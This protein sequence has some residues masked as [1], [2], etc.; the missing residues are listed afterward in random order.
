MVGFPYDDLDR[1]RA[2]YPAEIFATQLEKVADGFDAALAKL[3]RSIAEMRMSRAEQTAFWSALRVAEAAG[4]HFRSVAI[5]ARFIMARKALDAAKDGAT[6]TPQIEALQ[7]ILHNEIASARRLS[8]V[9]G[10]DSRIGF[11]ASNQYY[12]VGVD[13][14]EKVLNCRDLLDR[15][16]PE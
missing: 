4:I 15:W 5:Q 3:K 8:E 2:I 14:A 11:E 1:W 7:A 6:A 9:Q 12:Y 10:Q 16:L 13:L